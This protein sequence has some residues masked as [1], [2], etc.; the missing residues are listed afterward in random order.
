MARTYKLKGHETFILREGWLTKGLQAVADDPMVFAEN[1]GADALGVG[2]NMAKA[3]RYWMKAA[4]ILPDRTG[5]ESCLT[6]LGQLLYEYDPY[7]EDPFSLWLVH[8]GIAGNETGATSWYLFFHKMEESF[9]K[10]ELV[11]EMT[12]WLLAYTT[13][14][15]LSARSVRDDCNALIGMYYAERDRNYDPEDKKISPFAMLGLLQKTGDGY[16]K[17]QPDRKWLHRD[18]VL[19]CMIRML[20]ADWESVSIDDL[21]T[22]NCSPG[23]LLNLSRTTLNAYLDELDNAEWITVN[24]TAGL[25]MVYRARSFTPEEL[26]QEYYTHR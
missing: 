25:D 16:Q 14:D 9:T 24:R 3:I 22:G 11:E 15:K 10:E 5:K 2:T 7:M 20:G 12:G 19:Y 13:E 4:G 8:L 21:M 17:S 23:R 26:I 1:H 18:V 6:E